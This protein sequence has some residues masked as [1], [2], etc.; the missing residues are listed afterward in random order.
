MS[1]P[2]GAE[3]KVIEPEI[4]G[5]GGSPNSKAAA[6]EQA[7]PTMNE[8]GTETGGLEALANGRRPIGPSLI[9][10]P[11]IV[12]PL[13]F[14]APFSGA[15]ARRGRVRGAGD[16]SFLAAYAALHPERNFL[17]VERLLGRLRKLDRKGLRRALTKP[18]LNPAGSPGIWPRV[19]PAA[20]PRS[21]P[22]MSIF[23][24]R[25]PSRS[26]AKTG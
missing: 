4:S 9:H 17:G 8:R 21:R 24:T 5:P 12:A 13:P 3:F 18:S 26:I 2:D 15:A 10:P 25:G 20:M 23:P 11:S 19:P 22:C 14:D 7:K 6:A 1:L 16:G